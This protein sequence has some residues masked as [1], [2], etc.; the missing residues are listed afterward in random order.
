[1]NEPKLLE[2]DSR[3]IQETSFIDAN[4]DFWKDM[5]EDDGRDLILVETSDHPVINHSNAIAAKMVARAKKLRIAWIKEGHTD[6]LLMRSYSANSCFIGIPLAPFLIRAQCL[7][8]SVFYYLFYVLLIDRIH[9]FWYKGVPYGDFIYDG[10]LAACSVATLHRFDIRITAI[11]YKLLVN[12]SRARTVLKN[13][14]IKAILTVHYIGLDFGPLSRV[15]MQKGI[16]VYW[17]SGGH[18]I[19]TLAVFGNLDERYSYPI[20]PTLR[21]VDIL[22]DKMKGTVESD[23]KDF[24]A[25]VNNP[26]YGAFSVAYNNKLTSDM[27]RERFLDEMCL[28]D[29]PIVFVMLHAFNDFPHSHFKKMLFADY[30][31]WFQQTLQFAKTDTSKN[32]IFKEHPANYFY[33][34]KDLDLNKVMKRLPP[35]IRYVSY[36]SDISAATVLNVADA[37]V[38]CLGTAGMEMPALRGIPSVIASDTFFDGFGFTIEPKSQSDYFETLKNFLPRP[39]SEE[40]KLKA[41]AC[42]LYIKKY[43]SVPFAAGP[44]MTFEE[45]KMPEKL[46]EIYPQRVMECYRDHAGL[47]FRQFEEYAQRIG[48][49]DFRCLLRFDIG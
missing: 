27:S 44:G 15:A 25:Q 33:P 6:E 3:S 8:R 24:I 29:K 18:E 19:F 41:K 34:T 9:S 31:D 23:L 48:R 37:V 5:R 42:Y 36:Q 10:Y 21:E 26:N 2:K 14:N 7:A 4:M 46:K 22:S 1:M 11:F 30:Y 35:H 43:S 38:T 49:P 32:W 40:Q 16:P 13:E 45:S 20:K 28:P 17:K 47:I 12:D 39:L